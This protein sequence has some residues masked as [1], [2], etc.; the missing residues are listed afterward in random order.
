MEYYHVDVFSREPFAGN[1]LTVIL[2]SQELDEEFMQ[3]TAQ[4]LKQFETIFLI[5]KGTNT[6][7]ARI[8]TVEEELD[9]VKSYVKIQQIRFSDRFVVDFSF[10][11]DILACKILKMLLQP[12]V[13]NSIYHGLEPKLGKGHLWIS[14]AFYDE[15]LLISIRDDGMGIDSDTFN[16]I[17]SALEDKIRSYTF[18]GTYRTGLGIINVNNRIK[19]IY[20]EQYGIAGSSTPGYETNVTLKIP[21]RR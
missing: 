11:Q 15:C 3:K 17:S 13:E 7:R 1:G 4:E 21:I 16:S 6:F 10:S 2:T 14:A 5:K 8:F 9:I 19:L 12:I 18:K 20:G